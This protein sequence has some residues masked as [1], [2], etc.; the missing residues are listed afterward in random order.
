MIESKSKRESSDSL[1]DELDDLDRVGGDL[2]SCSSSPAP[3]VAVV[4]VV[5]AD[6]DGGL[7][8]LLGDLSRLIQLVLVLMLAAF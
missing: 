2:A 8:S 3:F 4:A 7:S 1:D 5:S 6:S